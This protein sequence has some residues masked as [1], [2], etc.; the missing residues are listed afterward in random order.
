VNTCTRPRLPRLSTRLPRLELDIELT[1]LELGYRAAMAME[2]EHIR[3]DLVR[4][5]ADMAV[6]IARH[7]QA[8]AGAALAGAYG[9]QP[10][11]YLLHFDRRYR[12]A[13]HYTGWTE[14]LAA[15]LARHAVGDGARLLAVVHQAGITW[16]LARVWSGP[17]A[18][19]RQLKRQGG[20][21][22]HCPLC[23]CLPGGA[24]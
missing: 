22:R 19:E 15:R 9:R 21:S 5:R 3:P 12:H 17:R 18:R 4:H 7:R 11:V 10:V 6:R 1:R 24:Q 20:A 16:Q 14:D 8:A 2:I 23:K 13:G